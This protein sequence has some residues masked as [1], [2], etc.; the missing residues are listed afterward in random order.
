MGE[1]R[2]GKTKGRE[3]R[4]EVTDEIDRGGTCRWEGGGGTQP[5]TFLIATLAE[6]LKL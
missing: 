6:F 3:C 4:R 1:N 2:K 5:P